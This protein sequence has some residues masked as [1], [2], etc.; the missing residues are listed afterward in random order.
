[1]TITAKI[2]WGLGGLLSIVAGILA[3]CMPGATLGVLSIVL[4]IMLLLI[5]IS[6]IASYI[7]ER[8]AV[9]G[10]GL[11]LISGIATILLA[12][13]VFFNE[14]LVASSLP[15]VFAIWVLITGISRIFSAIGQKRIGYNYWWI[16]L[17]VGIVLTVLAVLAFIEPVVSAIMLTI[18]VGVYLVIN[19]CEM[20][21]EL[22]LANRL[23]N[24]AKSYIAKMKSIE[25]EPID[26]TK[27]DL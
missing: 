9:L 25:V 24:V 18:L 3:F 4:G 14:S 15:I 22:Y 6:L 8:E 2:V 20:L 1:M 27:K 12:I 21:F 16:S 5:G 23:E 13:F 19:G 17:I 26:V 10:A 11:M 7:L